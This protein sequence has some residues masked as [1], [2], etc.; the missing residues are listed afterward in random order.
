MIMNCFVKYDSYKDI[1]SVMNEQPMEER[2]DK[3]DQLGKIYEWELGS[4][5]H[6]KEECS[7]EK[8]E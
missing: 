6:L 5:G 1:K 3:M 2:K 4:S 7:H 8:R